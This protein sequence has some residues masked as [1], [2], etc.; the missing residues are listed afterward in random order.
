VVS[1]VALALVLIV[2]A[3]LMVRSFSQLERVNPGFKYDQLLTAHIAVPYDKYPDLVTT[4]DLYDRIHQRLERLPG[5]NAA[6]AASAVPFS[7]QTSTSQ[8]PVTAENA[9]PA[10]PNL[11]HANWIRVH[12][13]YLRTMQIPLRRGEDFA[14]IISGNSQD[15][16]IISESAARRLWDGE[17]PIGKRLKYGAADSR[18]PWRTVIGVAEDVRSVSLDRENGLD[19]Y[20]PYS[21][22]I[23]GAMTFVL[24]TDVEPQSLSAAVLREIW[25]EDPEQAVFRIATM[26]RMM[27][28]SLWPQRVAAQLLIF[29]AAAALI[30]AAIGIHGVMTYFVS[31]RRAEFGIRLTLG[32]SPLQL[33]RLVLMEALRLVFLGCAAGLVIALG[34]V[35][36]LAALLYGVRPTDMWTF[37]AALLVLPVVAISTTCIS[38][39]SATR[40]DPLKT[41]RSGQ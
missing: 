2:A 28:G 10:D 17:N 23:A 31:Q 30:L 21:Q 1:E 15:I 25:Q 6:S 4:T 27:A 14:S 9:S 35:Q 13:A 41:L 32:A 16:A 20:V 38:A 34:S 18:S 33:I 29:F 36:L 3:G 12:P 5:V 8:A 37:A 26:D 19:I 22:M 40:T 24:R 39:W 7:K 11:P